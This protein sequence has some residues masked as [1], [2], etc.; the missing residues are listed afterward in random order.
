MKQCAL[1]GEDMKDSKYFTIYQ[2][3]GAESKLVLVVCAKDFADERY[4]EI[5]MRIS[6]L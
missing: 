6:S 1:C 4:R 5:I 3:K 2:C